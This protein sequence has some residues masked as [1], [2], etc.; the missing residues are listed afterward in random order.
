MIYL[1]KAT[2]NTIICEAQTLNT[3]GF[4]LWRFVHDQYKTE[5]LLYITASSSTERFVEFE[6]T[7]PTDVDLAKIGKWSYYVYDGNGVSIDYTNMTLLES[8]MVTLS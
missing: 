4:Y 2:T 5:E 1:T 7:L 3:T 8:G 6:L